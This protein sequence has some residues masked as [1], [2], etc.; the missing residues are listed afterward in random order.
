VLRV[1]CRGYQGQAGKPRS[2][3]RLHALLRR[4][5]YRLASWEVGPEEINYRRF[6]DVTQLISLRMEQPLVFQACHQVVFELLQRGEITGLRIDHPDGL[7]DPK[8]YLERLQTE[9][10]ACHNGLHAKDDRSSSRPLYV[11][12][13][14]V[15]SSEEQLPSDWPVAG[16]T[17]YEFLHH[18]NGLFVDSRNQAALDGIYREFTGSECDFAECVHQGKKL[19]LEHSL[20]SELK[21]LTS[22]LKRLAAQMRY[23]QDLTSRQLHEALKEL[24][25][26]FPV[27]RTYV[28]EETQVLPPSERGCVEKAVKDARKRNPA[29][30][31][32]VFD[33]IQN[34]L[35]LRPDPELDDVVRAQSR[36][37]V[38][39]F[40]QL[41]GPAAAKGAE[42]TAFYNYNRLISLNEVGGDA[43]RFGISVQTFHNFNRDR[44][45]HRPH[46]LSA[47]ATHDTKRGEDVR[48]RINVLSEIPQSWEAAVKRWRQWNGDKKTRVDGTDAPHAND[49]YLLYQSLIGSWPG[50][51]VR[52]DEEQESAG[53]QKSQG[54]ARARE[55]PER[56][57]NY[58]TK[59]I[60]EAKARTNW[61][62]PNSTYEK[63]VTHFV[64]RILDPAVSPEFFED[65]SRFQKPV[66]FFGRC[67]SLAQVLLKITS[68]G[69]P[70]FYQGTELWDLSLVDPDNRRPVDYARRWCWLEE[71]KAS[72]ASTGKALLPF[73]AKLLEDG[74]SGQVKLFLIQRA[75][76]FRQSHQELF[77]LGEY[78]P[79]EVAGE[80]AEHICAFARVHGAQ[81]ALT[82]APRLVATLTKGK[83][84]YP[85]GPGVWKDTRLVLR[86]DVRARRF[87]NVLTGEQIH[88]EA[89]VMPVSAALTSFPVAL[90]EPK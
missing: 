45:R 89:F 78:I 85:L 13:E 36:E 49:E 83:E 69:V 56:M 46:A 38:M 77:A 64:E 10:S 20:V 62:R 5:H 52:L 12:V 70:D 19:I 68:P 30:A 76:Q 41:T 43:A 40:Q 88:T 80:R 61:R 37:F 67:N 16:T 34:L 8:Q 24:I 50:A 54:G 58:M 7:W 27:Y 55:F 25:A 39:H 71:V 57:G 79:I 3:D 18:I 60:K 32:A 63:A 1:V 9:A 6:F 42:D 17:G 26:S 31:P 14:K 73:V 15:L 29:I 59:A 33:F 51:E 47:T 4:Q 28:T 2:F 86:G 87:C 11:V 35:L 74:A 84:T 44:A 66:G 82:V 90:L 81:G 48:A 65:F 23:G 53:A 21:A 72:S 75:L 22:R